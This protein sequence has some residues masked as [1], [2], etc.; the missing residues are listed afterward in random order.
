MFPTLGRKA[1]LLFTVRDM[2]WGL[3]NPCFSKFSL[4]NRLLKAYNQCYTKYIK[5]ANKKDKTN[6]IFSNSINEIIYALHA[7]ARHKYQLQTSVICTSALQSYLCY[8]FYEIADKKPTRLHIR[9]NHVS[10]S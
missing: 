5:I 8:I 4:V 9:I 6:M 10:Q 1:W 2:C 7:S 3:R